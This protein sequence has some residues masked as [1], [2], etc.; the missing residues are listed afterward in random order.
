[1][2]FECMI[3]PRSKEHELLIQDLGYF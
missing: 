2:P 1:M 3:T